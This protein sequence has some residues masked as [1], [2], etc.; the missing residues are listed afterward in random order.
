FAHQ[1]DGTTFGEVLQSTEIDLADFILD[2]QP[3]PTDASLTLHQNYPNPF[4]PSTMVSFD[5]PTRSSVVLTVSDGLGREVARLTD[6]VLDSGRHS[7][8]F[9]AASLP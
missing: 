3:L 6:D 4:N 7:M 2:V 5:L 9:N 8:S 1:S